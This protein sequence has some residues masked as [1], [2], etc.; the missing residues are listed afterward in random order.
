[1]TQPLPGF[2]QDCVLYKIVLNEKNNHYK[3]Q[4]KCIVFF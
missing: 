2:E 4:V 1:M 3:Y